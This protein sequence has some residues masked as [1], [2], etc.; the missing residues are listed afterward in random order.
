MEGVLV[1][2]VIESE[3]ARGLPPFDQARRGVARPPIAN[4][5]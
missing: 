1:D 5:G 2:F 3:L 4:G